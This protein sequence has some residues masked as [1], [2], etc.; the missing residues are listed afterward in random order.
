[1]VSFHLL[2]QQVV[3]CHLA[4]I[5]TPAL[6]PAMTAINTTI[7]KTVLRHFADA[8]EKTGKARQLF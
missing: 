1:V 7:Q 3:I 5:I 2:H 8:P 6:F 4:T